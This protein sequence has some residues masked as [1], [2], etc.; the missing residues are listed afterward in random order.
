[1]N[2]THLLIPTDHG[3]KVHCGVCGAG[4]PVVPLTLKA[5]VTCAGCQQ[6][7]QPAALGQMSASL[8]SKRAETE[9]VFMAR[10]IAQARASGWLVYH[11]YNSRRS[12]PGFPDLVL[13]KAGHPILF[14]ECKTD[15]GCLTTAQ[16][17]WL[18]AIDGAHG[19]AETHVWRPQDWREILQQILAH[20]NEGGR[21]PH[22]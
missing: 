6:W 8:V 4:D 19:E 20:R 2:E 16:K 22:P 18:A 3:W 13:C 9:K 10:V 21:S 14:A 17:E 12:T 5:R 15:T 11:T 1:M 7:P